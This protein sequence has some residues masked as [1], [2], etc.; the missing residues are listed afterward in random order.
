MNVTREVMTDLLPVYF[1]G[2]ASQD[3]KR[4]M[5]EY[6]RQDPDF[7]RI[8]RRAAR[9]L[10]TL[11]A[12]TPVAPEAEREKRDLQ[13]VRDELF[14]RRLMFGMALLFTFAPLVS[15]FS[16]GD[17]DWTPI[18][19]NPWL[20]VWYWSLAA[21]AW[22]LYFARL[23]RRTFALVQAIYWTVIPLVWTFHLFLP[24]WEAGL[25]TRLGQIAVP[26]IGAVIAWM[27]YSRLRSGKSLL[28]GEAAG[29]GRRK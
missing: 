10:E 5:E 21:P 4:L 29:G 1:S 3:T 6:F 22:F 13:W 19:N 8:A 27:L 23:R 24:G 26:W 7:E 25:S 12:S 18:S 14:R 28:G 20:A 9:P 2:E 15:V 16:H 11:R 17:L